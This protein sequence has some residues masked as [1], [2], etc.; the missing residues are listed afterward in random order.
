MPPPC[1]RCRQSKAAEGDSW[2]LACTGWE[3]LGRDL[4]GT[5]DSPGCRSVASDL[6]IS[7]VRQVRALRNLG[8]GLSRAS[9]LQ[10]AGVG[11]GTP[12]GKDRGR[13]EIPA[14]SAKS[15]ATPPRPSLPRLRTS[16]A[17]PPPTVKSEDTG[18]E[19]PLAEESEEEDEAEEEVPI[20]DPRSGGGGHHRPPEPEGPPPRA[21]G[22]H[23]SGGARA[24]AAGDTRAGSRDRRRGREERGQRDRDRTRSG[25]RRAGRKH[26]RLYRCASDP[27]LRV[28]RKPPNNFWDLGSET[29]GR[30]ALDRL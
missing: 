6:V 22:S 9:G 30:Q 13:S 3:A 7:C 12:A 5:W 11:V 2:C 24:G 23:R 27:G 18:E 26:Q 1:N 28:H 17:P 8:A 20:S 16:E 19:D 21:G 29:Q 15:G 10:A 25:R 4:A 14:V